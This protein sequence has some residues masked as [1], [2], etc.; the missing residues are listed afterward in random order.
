MINSLKLKSKQ[1]NILTVD[2]FSVWHPWHHTDWVAGDYGVWLLPD[3][4]L[5]EVY[6]RWRLIPT[7]LHLCLHCFDV[8]STNCSFTCFPWSWSY[9]RDII[10]LLWK[11]CEMCLV[12]LILFMC[13]LLGVNYLYMMWDIM[14]DISCVEI[15]TYQFIQTLNDILKFMCVAKTWTMQIKLIFGN[16][17]I[18]M[19]LNCLS[20]RAHS[21]CNH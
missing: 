12:I 1:S 2:G 15:Y 7:T 5:Q 16:F 14:F 13:F 9:V 10:E 6:G 19:L 4:P 21:V 8:F 17:H 3:M 20:E 11:L 18:K